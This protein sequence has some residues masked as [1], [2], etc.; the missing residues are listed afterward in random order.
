MADYYLPGAE[1]TALDWFALLQ[2]EAVTAEMAG[3]LSNVGRSLDISEL[4]PTVRVPALVI[5]RR[6]DRVTTLETAREVAT[7][8]P[9]AR[10]AALEG[11]FHIPEFGDASSV[12]RA[13]T[14]FVGGRHGTAPLGLSPR[15]VEVLRLIAAGLSNTEIADRLVLSVR[16]VERHTV[17]IYAKIG[18]RGRTEATA[19]AVQHG[20]G[21]VATT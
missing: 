9:N 12:L 2:R 5:N 7:L 15:E 14:E 10:L 17:N 6:E 16:T 21:P 8:I 18:A 3:A 4:L 13:I 20:L 1:I 19:Y 11:A